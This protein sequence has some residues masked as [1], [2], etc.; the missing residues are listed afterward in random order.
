M[1]CTTGVIGRR[2]ML[3]PLIDRAANK[4]CL[5]DPG[6]AHQKTLPPKTAESSARKEIVAH[7]RF[8]SRDPMQ[9][10]H[11]CIQ[12]SHLATLFDFSLALG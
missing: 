5:P 6:L 7:K 11:L 12:K 8:A 2:W 9:E 1:Q 10:D 4:R 3:E